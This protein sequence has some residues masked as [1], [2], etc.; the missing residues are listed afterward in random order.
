[1]RMKSRKYGWKALY[2]KIQA[3]IR[4]GLI[5]KIKGKQE[6]ARKEKT[7]QQIQKSIEETKEL[8]MKNGKSTRE[9]TSRQNRFLYKKMCQDEMM[10]VLK[11]NMNYNIVRN[12]NKKLE[13]YG[14]N[15]FE[16]YH[17][18]GLFTKGMCND[19][20]VYVFGTLY[21]LGYVGALLNDNLVKSDYELIWN[22]IKFSAPE[23]YNE[24]DVYDRIDAQREIIECIGYFPMCFNELR[25][26][27]QGLGC[28]Y[29]NII[30]D[31]FLWHPF[32]CAVCNENCNNKSKEALEQ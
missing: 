32:N 25:N 9:L 6:Q 23:F 28:K 3:Q 20:V 29:E 4:I 31:T 1:M 21:Q 13:E 24:P 19:F 8:K 7:Y 17:K 2:R 10:G 27:C 11:P 15:I 16:S 5:G 18:Y 12:I 22:V 14:N 26:Q 30:D